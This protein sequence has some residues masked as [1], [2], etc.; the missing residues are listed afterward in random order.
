MFKELI[1]AEMTLFM[2]ERKEVDIIITTALIPS[3]PAPKLVTKEMVIQMKQGLVTVD[4][5]T[6]NGG[7]CEVTRAGEMHAYVS[8]RPVHQ[9][10]MFT[11][12]HVDLPSP[13][14]RQPSTLYPNNIT[15]FLLALTPP[16]RGGQ[17][18]IDMS[19]EIARRSV[20]LHQGKLLWPAPAPP[21]PPTP[22][23]PAIEIRHKCWC[24]R[25]A[26]R[27]NAT[28]TSRERGDLARSFLSWGQRQ[29]LSLDL[30]WQSAFGLAGLIGYRIVWGVTPALHSPLMSVTNAIS[31]GSF[32]RLE[33]SPVSGAVGRVGIGSVFI[34]GGGYFLEM[35]PQLLGATPVLL[36][37]VNVFALLV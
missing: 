6:E 2:E 34:M 3:K 37:S 5:A 17:L 10:M 13:L 35:I 16:I 8:F 12:L 18:A 33:V 7:N 1:A 29:R 20:V 14:V 24:C 11:R 23:P 27:N 21:L 30:C 22:A 4:L 19:D 32:I 9:L 26:Q 36:A 25:L 31:G 15:E 28:H